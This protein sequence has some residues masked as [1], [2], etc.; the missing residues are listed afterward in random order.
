MRCPSCGH[1]ESKVIDS[2]SSE[3]QNATRRRRECLECGERFTT[4]E[5]L[6]E[7]PL[8]VQKSDGRTEPFDFAKLKRGILTAT[9]KRPVSSDQIDEL[10]ASIELDLQNTFTYTVSS[11][12][13]GDMVLRKLKELD[14]VA[15]V[16]FA[17]VYKDFQ[18]LEEFTHEL[19]E[20]ES[21]S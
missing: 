18:D 8:M 13:L 5:R 9:T 17:S 10:I 15:Y 12:M 14:S 6:E 19:K 4:Y 3:S 21:E 16:R 20:L 7:Q 1:S 2:R 11:S